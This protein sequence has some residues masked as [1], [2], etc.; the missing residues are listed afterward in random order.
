MGRTEPVDGGASDGGTARG[1]GTA[2]PPLLLVNSLE[3]AAS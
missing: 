1:Y 2:R 3:K